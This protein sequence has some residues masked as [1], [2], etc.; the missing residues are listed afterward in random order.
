MSAK[1]EGAESGGLGLSDDALREIQEAQQIKTQAAQLQRQ[2]DELSSEASDHTRVI[3]A[4]KQVDPKRTCFRSI[5]GVLVERK[6]ENVLPELESN[7]SKIIKACKTIDEQR[8]ALEK[9]ASDILLKHSGS[10]EEL[11][12]RKALQEQL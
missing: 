7:L 2:L 12:R 10:L 11:G 6:V 8:K 4:L 3:D 1:V 5:G 9:E